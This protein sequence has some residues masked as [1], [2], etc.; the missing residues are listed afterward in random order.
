[1]STA[2]LS[3]RG[4]AAGRP[5]PLRLTRRGRMVVGGLVAAPVAAVLLFSALSSP[6]AAGSDISAVDYATVTVQPGESLWGIA[7]RIAP[8]ADPRDVIADIERLNALDGSS[9]AAGQSL[10]VPAG[11]AD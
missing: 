1:M 10:A 4:G 11:Y 3:P 5:A 8:D 6:A 9:V 2:A 7:E